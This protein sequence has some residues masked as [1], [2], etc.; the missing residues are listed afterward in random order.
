MTL[1]QEASRKEGKTV[2]IITHNAAFEAIGDRVIR[3]NSG[4]IVEEK[5]NDQP[6]LA[7]GLVW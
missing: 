1:L 4:T 3:V 5:I 2:V 7:E 6:A